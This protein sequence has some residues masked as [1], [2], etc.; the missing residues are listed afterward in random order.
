MLFLFTSLWII[1]I[2]TSLWFSLV[3][4]IVYWYKIKG[5]FCYNISYERFKSF[6]LNIYLFIL[7]IWVHCNCFQTHRKRESDHIAYGCEP[8]RGCWELTSGPL[9][10]QSVLL[11]TDPSFYPQ[12]LYRYY[13]YATHLRILHLVSIL[14]IAVTITC[15]G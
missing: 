6:I 10:E 5:W 8:Q 15:L 7:C 12:L 3:W 1:I 11:T 13:A 9:D 4:V 2:D 14:L